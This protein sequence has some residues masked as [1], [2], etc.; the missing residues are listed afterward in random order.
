MSWLCC[1]PCAPCGGDKQTDSFPSTSSSQPIKADS[2]NE[3]NHMEESST[4]WVCFTNVCGL[5]CKLCSG[6][7]KCCYCG[8]DDTEHEK[9]DKTIIE[10]T[11]YTTK[12]LQ[13]AP[14]TIAINC[15]QQKDSHWKDLFMIFPITTLSSSAIG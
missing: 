12:H 5:P 11:E 6:C 13:K 15:F 9:N 14:K 2:Y 7:S 1:S 8:H 3:H 10:A 4:C